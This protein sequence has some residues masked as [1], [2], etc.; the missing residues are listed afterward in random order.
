MKELFTLPNIL[1]VSR[2]FLLPFFLLGF[3]LDSQIGYVISFS[4]FAICCI[5]DYLD[6]Y[7]ARVLKQV[8]KIGQFLDPLADKIL[9]SIAILSIFVFGLVSKFILIPA[10]IILCREIAITGLRDIFEES[11][12]NFKTSWMSKWK[13]AI[14]MIS[15]SLILLA[16]VINSESIK[17]SGE[18]LFCFAALLALISGLRYCR[19]YLISCN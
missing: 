1:T 14:Q 10:S 12:Q 7:Y 5:T 9:V 3:F 4:I 17:V 15:I 13:T 11:G 8:T 6:G 19:K 16:P 2:F 18:I